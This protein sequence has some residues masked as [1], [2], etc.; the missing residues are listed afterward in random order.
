VLLLES[1]LGRDLPDAV[2]NDPVSANCAISASLIYY[3]EGPHRL[4]SGH[5]AAQ[6]RTAAPGRKRAPADRPSAQ[7]HHVRVRPE[8]K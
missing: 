2:E 7:T 5:S 3:F 8:S 1:G 6:P 4:R